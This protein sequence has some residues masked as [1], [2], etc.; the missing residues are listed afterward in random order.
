MDGFLLNSMSAVGRMRTVGGQVQVPYNKGLLSDKFSAALQI[1]RRAWRSVQAI[2]VNS[3]KKIQVILLNL[4][5]SYD[6]E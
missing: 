2:R 6:N 4:F 5:R 3:K 1:F